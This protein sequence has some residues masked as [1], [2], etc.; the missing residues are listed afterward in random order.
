MMELDINTFDD[1]SPQFR[2]AMEKIGSDRLMRIAGKRLEVE[3][4]RHFRTLDG[5]GNKRGWPSRHTWQRIGRATALESVSQAHATVAIADPA[6]NMKVY[7]GEVTPKRA[8]RLAM[9]ATAAAYAAGSP[10]EGA[11]PELDISFEKNPETGKMQMALVVKSTDKTQ[12]NTV[13]YWLIRKAT[14]PAEADALPPKSELESAISESVESF[15]NRS[16]ERGVA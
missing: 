13:W 1:A 8:K 9:P 5:R 6:Y 12:P 2:A 7:G 11:A 16:M 15:V 3:L 10:R 14:I 4:R